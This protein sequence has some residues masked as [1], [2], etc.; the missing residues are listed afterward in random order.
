MTTLPR[1]APK[2]RLRRR[3][4]APR[5]I[6]ALMLREMSS[7]Y[8]RSPGGYLWAVVEPVAGI[9]ILTYASSLM[10]SNPPLGRSF[11]LFYATGM[12]PFLMFTVIANRVGTSLLF[13]R[14]LLVYPAVT[15]A[16]AVL[17]RFFV[18]LL[19]ELLIFVLVIAGVV[20]IYDTGAVLEP[21]KIAQSL[22]VTAAFALGVGTCNAYL[23]LRWH[24]WHV[25]WAL[26]SRPLFLISGV[27]FMYGAL[28]PSMREPLW[29]N[30]MIHAIGMLRAGFYPTYNDDYTSPAYVLL[31]SMGL[32]AV[33]FL[34]L[35]R[36]AKWLLHEGG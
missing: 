1:L 7:T 27:F 13:S 21:A 8:G 11:E 31:V 25:F 29:Y 6:A 33:A 2:P 34:A 18:N 4:A 15:F 14:P 30:P 36:H 5:A 20:L 24:L 32:F 26:I 23:F 19:T 10:F 9:A 35:A 22:S 3:F 17:A 12:L 16:D 28:P